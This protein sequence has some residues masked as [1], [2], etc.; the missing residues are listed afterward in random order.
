MIAHFRS[1]HDNGQ[2]L[3]STP[4]P[5]RARIF[6]RSAFRFLRP[7]RPGFALPG[8]MVGA[9]VSGGTPHVRGHAAFKDRLHIRP[10]VRPLQS[11]VI[12]GHRLRRSRAYCAGR[13]GPLCIDGIGGGGRPA[14]RYCGAELGGGSASGTNGYGFPIPSRVSS[15]DGVPCGKVLSHRRVSSVCS[16]RTGRG[17]DGGRLLAQGE[18]GELTRVRSRS[19][20]D[21]PGAAAGLARGRPL[22]S[23]RPARRAARSDTPSSAARDASLDSARQRAASVRDHHVARRD[24]G[25]TSSVTGG[26]AVR[27]S[28]RPHEI[29]TTHH[30]ATAAR[31]TA[32]HG[33]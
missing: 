8:A 12:I 3:R 10:S 20:P 28:T 5:M 2:P 13:R 33:S 31:R 9:R 21:A 26:G 4:P 22:R 6:A 11:T 24:I 15:G 19:A 16:G 32:V 29:T 7:P 23:S 18:E 25:V 14:G 30:A 27:R 1:A 17:A